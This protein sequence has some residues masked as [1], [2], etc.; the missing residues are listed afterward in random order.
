MDEYPNS[1][2]TF[3]DQQWHPEAPEE[4]KETEAKEK[5]KVSTSIGAIQEVLDWFDALADT[6]SSIDNLDINERAKAEDVKLGILLAKKMRVELQSQAAKFRADF[7]KY[8]K[9]EDK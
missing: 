2:E 6:Y 4:Q 1:S 7:A 8:L 3:E 5:T 9:E